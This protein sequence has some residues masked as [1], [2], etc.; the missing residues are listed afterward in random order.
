MEMLSLTLHKNVILKQTLCHDTY[1]LQN[2]PY[3]CEFK[4]ARVVKQ[5]VWIKA[6]N[7]ERD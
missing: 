3:F 2:S 5:K 6:E 4:Y 1:R 7:R